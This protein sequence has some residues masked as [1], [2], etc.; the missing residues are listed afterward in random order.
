MAK[1]VVC[2]EDE[3][4]EAR[5]KIVSYTDFLQRKVEH[6]RKVLSWAQENG[7]HDNLISSELSDLAEETNRL[8]S[9]VCGAMDPE[10]NS[11]VSDTLRDFERAD[12]FQYPSSL[13]EQISSFLS[14][15][16]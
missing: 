5:N 4:L 6:Y 12:T 10:L 7:I 14:I 3:L 11:A 13:L 9:E 1:F 15:F 8:V 16:L 2:S